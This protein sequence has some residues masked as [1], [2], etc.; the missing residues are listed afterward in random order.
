[1]PK[2]VTIYTIPTCPWC[3]QTKEYLR[4]KGIQFTDHNVAEDRQ[5]FDAM[6]KLTGQAGVPVIVIDGK[7]TIGFDPKKIDEA[8]SDQRSR[9]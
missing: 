5:A 7:I 6:Y 4:Q 9:T 2:Q 3:R 1:L 8:L